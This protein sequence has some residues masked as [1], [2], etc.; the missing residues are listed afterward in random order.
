MSSFQC[1]KSWAPEEPRATGPHHLLSKTLHACGGLPIS[2]VQVGKLRSVGRLRLGIRMDS[3]ME[4]VI[5]H[6]NGQLREVLDSHF[7]E[8]FKRCVDMVLNNM[9]WWGVWYCW[10]M[11]GFDD[12]VG[13]F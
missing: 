12:S 2:F 7:L 6:W 1:W 11:V 9:V 5:R 10:L 13:H 4:G 8:V 3:F